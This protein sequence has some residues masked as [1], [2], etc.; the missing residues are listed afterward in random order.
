[1]NKKW[2]NLNYFDKKNWLLDNIEK[3]DISNNAK[4]LLILV[5][6]LEEKNIIINQNLLANKLSISLKELDSLLE[7]LI[8]KGLV[9]IKINN[10]L[11]FDLSKLFETDFNLYNNISDDIVKIYEKEK[12]KPITRYDLE[13]L[14]EL[15]KYYPKS[16]I[17]KAFQIAAARK[18]FNLSYIETILI[19]EKKS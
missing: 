19:N 18:Q 4:L 11:I 10:G 2:Y 8:T 3:L 5:I 15:I 9:N 6:F 12:V 7:D 13:K 14:D 16:S 1:M 17:I